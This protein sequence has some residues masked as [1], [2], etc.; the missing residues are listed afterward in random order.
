VLFVSHN[1]AAVRALCQ[2]AI[3]FEGGRIAYSGDVK[4]AID[5]YMNQDQADTASPVEFEPDDSL[6]AQI[7]S[8]SVEDE[9]GG[10]LSSMPHDKP[11][12][13]RLKVTARQPV[14]R[15]HVAIHVLEA[16]KDTI[17]TVRDIDERQVSLLSES[18]GTFT[19]RVRIPANLVPGKY[20][21][22]AEVC[23]KLQWRVKILDQAS[24]VWPFEIYDNGS[25]LSRM[26]IKW[27]GR[28]SV[29]AEWQCLEQREL[30][31]V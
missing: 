21:L 3:F 16:D 5:V 19:Y 23:Q 9:A 26:N 27:T 20:W 2:T 28:I 8:V 6:K 10:V 11:F 12:W 7:L 1:M 13:V 17:L 24:A 30:D 29:P 25:V 22:S 31:R 14:Y 18:A 4:H 15:G